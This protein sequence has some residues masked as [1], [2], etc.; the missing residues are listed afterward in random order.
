VARAVC[1]RAER[2]AVHLT[3]QA[4]ISNPP[5]L[6][7]LNRLSDVLWLFARLLEVRAKVDS[8]W[9]KKGSA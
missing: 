4:A 7:Y 3:E 9:Q 1:R 6:V 2:L 8:S 5:V